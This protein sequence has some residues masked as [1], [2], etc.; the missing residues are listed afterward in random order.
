MD[1]ETR[2][3]LKRAR[4][5]HVSATERVESAQVDL[6]DARAELQEATDDALVIRNELGAEIRRARSAGAS[7][8]EISE[9]LG[10]SRQ[11]AHQL[12]QD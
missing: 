10:I 2:K 12:T 5:R 6:A 9:L 8:A 1:S 11:R 3:R 4:S 7:L